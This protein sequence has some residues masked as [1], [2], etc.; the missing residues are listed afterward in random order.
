[1]LLLVSRMGVHSQFRGGDPRSKGANYRLMGRLK[2]ILV[3]VKV[4]SQQRDL[5]AKGA[6][7]DSLGWGELPVLVCRLR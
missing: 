3:P 2:E 4:S 6:L 1:M 5:G 7:V